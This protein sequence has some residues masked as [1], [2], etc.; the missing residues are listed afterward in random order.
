[1]TMMG[2]NEL[3]ERAAG[4]RSGQGYAGRVGMRNGEVY[5]MK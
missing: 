1:M 3:S 4:S 5:V 2:W